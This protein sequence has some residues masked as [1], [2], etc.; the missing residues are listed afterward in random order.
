[1]VSILSEGVM[2][3]SKMFGFF[4]LVIEWLGAMI[5]ASEDI[6]NA[7]QR[8][9]D[10]LLPVTGLDGGSQSRKLFPLLTLLIVFVALLLG[11]FPYYYGN[12]VF[13]PSQSPTRAI[14][15]GV[16]V[17]SLFFGLYLLLRL[18]IWFLNVARASHAAGKHGTHGFII[19]SIGV[20]LQLIGA[21]LEFV[22]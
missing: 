11:L 22:V 9:L 16:E 10:V 19:L 8:C 12:E 3:Y 1:M 7:F 21:A 17:A 18:F 6:G 13:W 2:V 5:L 20:L 4:G 14:I 15:I